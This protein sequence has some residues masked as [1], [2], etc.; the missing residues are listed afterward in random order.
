MRDNAFADLE[1]LLELVKWARRMADVAPLKDMIGRIQAISMRYA[2]LMCFWRHSQGAQPRSGA[3]DRRGAAWYA[4]LLF[5][6]FCHVLKSAAPAWT[7]WIK[8]HLLTTFRMSSDLR[9]DCCA[10]MYSDTVGSCSM[11]PKDKGG[12]VDPSLKV[13]RHPIHHHTLLTTP[14]VYG[15]TNLR[16]ADIS[17]VPLHFGSHSLCMP[18]PCI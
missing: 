18:L 7:A 8:A 4:A 15:T 1:I 9:E 10:H 16:V 17:V 11:L 12:V 13:C 3:P 5:C 2:I 14:Q 6:T